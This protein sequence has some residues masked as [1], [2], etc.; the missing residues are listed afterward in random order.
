MDVG[1]E[2]KVVQERR[3]NEDIYARKEE[4]F[5]SNDDD[6]LN[7]RMARRE[8]EVSQGGKEEEKDAICD[9]H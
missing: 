3:K 9:G 7:M 6:N 8:Y 5:S 2:K 4:I 1:K